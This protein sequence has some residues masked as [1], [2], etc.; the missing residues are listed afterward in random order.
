MPVDIR[1]LRRCEA[2]G[3]WKRSTITT[4]VYRLAMTSF[5]VV[6]CNRLILDPFCG[7]N[8]AAEAYK[9]TLSVF[10]DLRRSWKLRVGY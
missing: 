2:D 10:Y 3:H 6:S 7:G 8:S 5:E 9:R 4:S 1:G